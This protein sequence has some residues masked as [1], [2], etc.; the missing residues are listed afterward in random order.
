MCSR[1]G[2]DARRSSLTA[3]SSFKDD[4]LDVLMTRR[5]SRNREIEQAAEA[6]DDRTSL[7]DQFPAELTRRYTLVFKARTSAADSPV[8]ALAVRQV[9]GDHLGHLITVRGIATR[10]T[11]VKPIAAVSAYTCDRCGCEIFQPVSDKQFAPLAVCPSPQCKANQSKG[12]L[13]PS[14][15]ASK[16]LPFQEVKIQELAE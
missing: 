2:R 16:F 7:A 8:K 15:R 5:K 6:T 3:E 11:D 12:Q 13:Y 4:V 1:D 14:S 9:R 10:V